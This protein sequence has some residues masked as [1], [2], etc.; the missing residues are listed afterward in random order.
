MFWLTASSVVK[1]GIEIGFSMQIGIWVKGLVW[2]GLVS[3]Y[4][5][6]H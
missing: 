5:G 3:G 4:S 6:Y 1:I 2:D